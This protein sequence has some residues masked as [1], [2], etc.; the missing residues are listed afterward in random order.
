MLRAQDLVTA[1]TVLVVG[2]AAAEVAAVSKE[3]DEVHGKT[4]RSWS[5]S[6]S[7]GGRRKA[8]VRCRSYF[9]DDDR[10]L[11]LLLLQLLLLPRRRRLL[12]LFLLLLLLL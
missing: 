7:S 12:L 10:L 6:Q 9:D 8:G 1:E 11:L 4:R 2:V 3:A 5:T